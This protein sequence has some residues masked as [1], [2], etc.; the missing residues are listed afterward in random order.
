MVFVPVNTVAFLTLPDHLRTDGA[1]FQTLMRNV[2][3]SFGISVVIAKLTEG[4]P[5]AHAELGDYVNPFN[6]A[7]KMP[8]VAGII[9]MATDADARWWTRC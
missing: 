3:S 5:L 2:S 4:A 7:L 9:N 6:D 8:D 1:S